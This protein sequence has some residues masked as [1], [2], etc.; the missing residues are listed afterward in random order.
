MSALDLISFG[1]LF[2][3][4]IAISII[5]IKLNKLAQEEKKHIKL[6]KSFLKSHLKIS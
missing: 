6:R 1:I 5:S 2:I 4:V 3:I